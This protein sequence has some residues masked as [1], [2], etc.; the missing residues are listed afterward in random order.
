MVRMS[1]SRIL[2]SSEAALLD[3]YSAREAYDLA[4]IKNLAEKKFG[5]ILIHINPLE[6][7]P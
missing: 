5:I 6:T 3:R 7:S 1:I 2:G 4:T